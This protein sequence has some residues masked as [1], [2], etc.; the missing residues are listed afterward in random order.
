MTM[1]DNRGCAGCA[2]ARPATGD[3]SKATRRDF[4]RGAAG[5]LAALFAAA[6]MAPGQLAALPFGSANGRPDR[7]GSVTYPLPSADGVTIDRDNEIIL[8]RWDARLYAFALSCP[9]QRTMLKWRE[10][11]AVFQCTKHKSKYHAD[12]TFI[13]G[14]ATRGMDRFPVRITGG[15]VT[16]D[17]SSAILQDEDETAWLAASAFLS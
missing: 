7:N 11:D 13:S 17:T 1:D 16:V 15:S 5:T 8:V 14:R 10:N 12:G 9:H 4:V 3:G 2:R 6:G